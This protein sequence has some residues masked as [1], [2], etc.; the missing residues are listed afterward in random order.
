MIPNYRLPASLATPLCA[1]TLLASA[2]VLSAAPASVKA[3]LETRPHFDEA[4]GNFTDVDDPAIWVHPSRPGSSLV[5]GTLK[6]GGLDL[7]TLEGKLRQHLPPRP[8]P[9]CANADSP[10]DNVA[11][12]LNNAEIVYAFP[13]QGKPTDLV[14]ASDR[15]FDSLAVFAL[16]ADDSGQYRLEDIT[17]TT[18]R[19]IFSADQAAVNA[20]YTAYGLATY[21]DQGS[22]MALVSQNST[23]RVALLELKEGANGSVGFTHRAYLDFPHEFATGESRW[24]PCS[25]DDIDRPQFEGMVADPAHNALYLAQEDVGIWRIAMDAPQDREQWQLFARAAEFGVPYDRQWDENAGEYNCTLLTE[26][27]PGL[28]DPHLHADLEGLTLYDAGD[29]NGYLLIS[30][31]GDNSVAVYER[32]AGNRYLGSFRVEDGSVDGVQETD[33]MMVTNVALGEAFPAG[34]LVMHD[35]DDQPTAQEGSGGPREATN[36]KFIDWASISK[37]LNLPMDTGNRVR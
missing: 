21:G 28:G 36:F 20:G 23:T 17:D 29:G 33:G 18:A 1:L 22:T 5:A 24:T 10:C 15:G 32:G 25:D 8:A 16:G 37:A 30:S 4:A 34:L 9:S 7:Y 3:T 11:G 2:Q 27:N 6:E 31:Q 35:G 12:R 14:V 26:E 19:P 13:L